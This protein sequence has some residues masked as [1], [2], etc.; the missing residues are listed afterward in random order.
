MKKT[1]KT[2]DSVHQLKQTN[3]LSRNTPPHPPGL[4]YSENEYDRVIYQ[5]SFLSRR[6]II[7]NALVVTRKTTRH[8]TWT[9]TNSSGNLHWFS[10]FGKDP[11]KWTYTMHIQRFSTGAPDNKGMRPVRVVVPKIKP[12]EGLSQYPGQGTKDRTYRG[13]TEEYWQMI[14]N[15][16][17]R[18]D[19]L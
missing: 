2:T 8:G 1:R 15:H 4:G 14:T 19:Q 10:C 5:V 9:R 17:M 7:Y 3:R 11:A 6:R 13:N 18:F 12:L 16:K